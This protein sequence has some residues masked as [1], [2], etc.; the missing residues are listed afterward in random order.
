[1]SDLTALL[2]GHGTL[3]IFLG[4]ICVIFG[5]TVAVLEWNQK[6]GETLLASWSAASVAA[7]VS[8]FGATLLLFVRP[9]GLLWGA[10]ML[11]MSVAV[12]AVVGTW[13]IGVLVLAPIGST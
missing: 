12:V 3:L 4:S 11:A 13:I 7:T 9:L 1:M 5:W 6:S 10:A 2:R 8:L